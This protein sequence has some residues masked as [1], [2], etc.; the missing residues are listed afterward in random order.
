M[1][2]VLFG[3]YAATLI[4]ISIYSS[5]HTG[6][7][8]DFFLGGRNVGPWMSAFAYGT[9]YFSAVI[10]VGYAG[11][12]GWNF[13]L[14]AVWIG[15]GNALIGSL[16]AW[17]VLA[18]KTR[19]M[20][21]A[22]GAST[23]PDFFRKRFDSKNLKIFSALIIFVFMV[24]YS[25]SVY[26]GLSYLF[27]ATFGLPFIYCIVAMA[28]LTALYLVM[29]GYLA[30][31][32]SDF[33]QG[34][35][36]L[37]GVVLVVIWV[38]NNPAGGGFSAGMDKLFSMDPNLA[39][40]VRTTNPVKLISLVLLTSLGSWGLPQMIHKFYAVR[41]GK[42]VK[43]AAFI[44][45]LFALVVAGGAYFMGVFGRLYMAEMPTDMDTIVPA[46]LNTA[47]MRSMG[48]EI[49]MGIVVI[50]VLSASMSTL[51]SLVLT[52]SSAISMDLVGGVWFPKM[53]EKK[54][55]LLMRVLCGFFVVLSALMA[56]FKI[57]TIVT[58]MSISWGTL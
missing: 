16:L 20:T 11:R 13:G 2:Y 34:I 3:I 39:S 29:G 35:I 23:M 12:F 44:S 32:L 40:L 17:L 1:Q 6:N 55:Q 21:H 25:A 51:S 49:L 28:A 33:V 36:M 58:L 4:G 50:L 14:S 45:T 31:A 56:V 26:Q 38:M 43:Q 54:V 53:P 18:K 15:I 24:P 22:L 46:M 42:A 41:D 7:L 37:V 10:F 30:T 19:N 47:L 9:T 27:E 52:A 8:K 57:E 48:G 5:K